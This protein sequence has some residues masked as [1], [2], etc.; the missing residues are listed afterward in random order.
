MYCWSDSTLCIV[1][2]TLHCV[3]LV[4]L[5]T[6]Y[7]WSYSTL[8]IV[9]LTLHCVLLVWLYTVYCWSDST[10]CIV[11]LTLHCVS[12]VLLYTVYCWSD[13]TLCIV[14]LTLHCVSLVWL[15]TVYCWSDSTLC[16]VGLT[17]PG[18]SKLPLGGILF[19]SQLYGM[20]KL[21]LE[22][23][24]TPQNSR[25]C[26]KKGGGWDVTFPVSCIPQAS[27]T[28]HSHPS[29]HLHHKFWKAP[30]ADDNLM[31]FCE[32]IVHTN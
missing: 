17:L 30:N 23:L 16:I 20:N 29:L 32:F 26:P 18:L 2:L 1:V 28:L 31:L 5:Y 8:C 19:L 6:V 21:L 25:L 7:C 22:D 12:L 13:S 11:G 27:E 24:G 14:G 15:Y 4:W 3:L 10:L 9:G